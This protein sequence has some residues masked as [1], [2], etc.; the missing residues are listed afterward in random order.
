LSDSSS[1]LEGNR[2]PDHHESFASGLMHKSDHT[3]AHTVLAVIDEYCE[4]LAV[5]RPGM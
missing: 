5:S 2:L 4:L 3:T 1:L